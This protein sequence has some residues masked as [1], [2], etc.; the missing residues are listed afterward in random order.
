MAGGRRQGSEGPGT[1][2]HRVK[3]LALS[4][5]RHLP[6]SKQG[7]EKS[8]EKPEAR[9]GGPGVHVRRA[10]AL[11][12]SCEGLA[13]VAAHPS[14]LPLREE[15]GGCGRASAAAGGC[16]DG[17][18]PCGGTGRTRGH[19]SG[20]A[21]VRKIATRVKKAPVRTRRKRCEK[22]RREGIARAVRGGGGYVWAETTH[23]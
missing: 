1:G 19:V 9:A 8:G 10:G 18:G 13:G 22:G 4:K 11:L 23:R 17:G 5:A 16:W 14:L 20:C 7:G 2:P 3:E 15:V 6:T 21:D 12:A